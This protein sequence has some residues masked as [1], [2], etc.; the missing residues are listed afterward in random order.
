MIEPR[1]RRQRRKNNR[2]PLLLLIGALAVLL[3][4]A[5]VVAV[6]QKL[7]NRPKP[8]E[9]TGNRYADVQLALDSP[10]QPNFTTLEES[11]KFSGTSD[12]SQSLLID[13]EEIAREADGSFSYNIALAVG[14]NEITVVHKDQTLQFVIS[15]RYAVQT[16]SPQGASSFNSEASMPISVVARQGS[17]VI[18]QFN[19]E[20]ISL[21]Q[22]GEQPSDVPAGFAL[23][24]AT[25]RMPTNDTKDKELGCIT[26]RVTCNAI[27]E[28]YTSGVIT[29]LKSADILTSNP[30]VTPDY[31]NYTDVGS[32]YIAEIITYSAETFYGDTRDDYSDPRNNYLPEGTVDYAAKEVV[33]DT[34]G[35]IQ[36]RLLR[37]GYR[38]YTEHKNY[39]PVKINPVVSCYKGTLPDHNEIGFASL[40]VS[41]SHTILTLDTVWKAPFYFDVEPQNYNN[42]DKRDYTISAMTAE[43]VDITFCYATQF[44]GTVNIPADNP[45]FSKA[46]LTQNEADCTLRLYLK[47][48]GG[49]YGW[50]CYYN[51]SN[52]LCFQFLN[53]VKATTGNNAYGADLT[54]IRVMI[55]VGHGG[56]DGGS[57]ATDANG[58]TVEEADCN[59]KL[60]MVLK[61]ELESM[62]A[63]VIMNRTDDSAV[64]VDERICFFKE[65]A[66]D[67]CIA[68]H[69]N[70]F[71]EMSSVSGC[72]VMYFSP[73]SQLAADAIYQEIAG[74]G[75]YKKTQ[76]KWNTYYVARISTSP[77]VLVEC[78][79]M[80]NP[81][82]LA[83][84]LNPAVLQQKA[85]SMAQGIANY[86]LKVK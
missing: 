63:T 75:V 49:F 10:K 28:T 21:S 29:C 12:P 85:E 23:Y 86:F 70:A 5:M 15:R 84:M 22:A 24:T 30:A 41:G 64:S 25:Y 46:T 60:A 39:P 19:A 20:Q 67:L 74:S 55:D 61:K 1:T 54:G 43:Y 27:T 16:F 73:Q 66:P 59:L 7:T 68:I 9:P 3:I 47:Q 71:K 62:G 50:D 57:P 83:G 53:P 33:Y 32:G 77:T 58:N 82:D 17:E 48:K 40:S 52:Q 42:P 31:G 65:K 81:D 69:Q 13:G 51:S 8:T 35:K 4:V 79:Y 34:K 72:E 37:C 18:A 36:Y 2:K 56:M 6:S 44:K 14:D 38:V 76:L 80:T 78:G 11:V 45:L 26:Y